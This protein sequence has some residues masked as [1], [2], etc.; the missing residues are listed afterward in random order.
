MVGDWYFGLE[1]AM[2]IFE[3][4][5]FEIR[6]V[7]Y[8]TSESKDGSFTEFNLRTRAHKTIIIKTSLFCGRYKV[9]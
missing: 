9:V 7:I 5:I 3:R 8:I 2:Q 1:S 4:K 6:Y